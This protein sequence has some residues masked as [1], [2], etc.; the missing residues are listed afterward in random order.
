M[1]LLKA[2]QALS[3]MDAGS[4]LKVIATDAGSWRDIPAFVDLTDHELLE[5]L[6]KD[7][8]FIFYIVKGK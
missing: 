1:P 7:E 6:Q 4:V 3:S 8:H 5:K 2:K